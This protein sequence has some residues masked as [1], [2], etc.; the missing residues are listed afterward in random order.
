LLALEPRLRGG[1]GGAIEGDPGR[2]W[3]NCRLTAERVGLLLG[4]AGARGFGELVADS[5]ALGWEVGPIEA[6][7]EMEEDE[8][9]LVR[10]ERRGGGGGGSF[11]VIEDGEDDRRPVSA[12]PSSE[13][14]VD[15]SGAANG[16]GL[17]LC[18]R[19]RGGGGT[20]RFCGVGL[21]CMSGD[22]EKD[23]R[24]AVSTSPLRF[25]AVS[26]ISEARGRAGNGFATPLGVTGDVSVVA[27]DDVNV[28]AE[29]PVNDSVGSSKDTVCGPLALTSL[30]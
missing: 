23:R 7:V 13:I 9:P 14:V 6:L 4:G 11:G 25:S 29:E 20:L 24:L 3:V 5:D 1:G 2:G 27:S 21:A 16:F 18:L 8:L 10:P 22:P 28:F 15:R 30:P 17:R 12:G 19:A 26:P